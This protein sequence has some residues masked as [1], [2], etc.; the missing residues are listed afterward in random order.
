MVIRIQIRI[1][2]GSH[3]PDNVLPDTPDNPGTAG[4]DPD[5]LHRHTSPI[6]GPEPRQTTRNTHSIPDPD[7]GSL[8]RHGVPR[9]SGGDR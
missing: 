7:S 9:L 6:P 2:L 5:S 4:P 1:L 3:L 8:A